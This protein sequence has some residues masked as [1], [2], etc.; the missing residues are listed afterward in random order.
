[1]NKSPEAAALAELAGGDQKTEEVLQ[2]VAKRF[3]S[4]DAIL[5]LV[6]MIEDVGIRGRAIGEFHAIACGGDD[7][8]FLTVIA[9]EATG[10]TTFGIVRHSSP[11]QLRALAEKLE[12][13]ETT[14]KMRRTFG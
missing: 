14:Q 10:V 3:S 8:L 12:K 1:M 4:S 5:G 9:N 11:D 6:M 7:Q 2:A 13:D